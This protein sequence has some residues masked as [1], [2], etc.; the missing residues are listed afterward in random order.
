MKIGQYL[1][2]TWTR[3][4]GLLF[5]AHP[6][7]SYLLKVADFNL[8]PCIWRPSWV[9]P[10]IPLKFRRDFWHQKTRVWAIVWHCLCDLVRSRFSSLDHGLV[11]DRQTDGHISV[12]VMVRPDTNYQ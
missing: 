5:L 6:V 3:V 2:K 1:A 12:C 11:T 8:P 4:S 9:D 10:V 7:V